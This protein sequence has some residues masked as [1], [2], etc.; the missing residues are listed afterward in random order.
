MH[1]PG[2]LARRPRARAT[3]AAAGAVVALLAVL[4]STVPGA[5]AQATTT[6]S[7]A[8]APLRVRAFG[9]SITAGYGFLGDGTEWD[10]F[11][12]LRCRPPV[13][14]LNDRC[15]S[16][17]SLGPSSPAGPPVFTPDFG[18]ANN[19]S[20][21]AQVT[22]AL[23]T[24]DY[25]NYSVTGSE[26]RQWMNLAPEPDQPD[27]GEYHD[28]LERL[29]SDDP[30][31]VLATL[32]AN[33]LLATFLTGPGM[34]CSEFADEATQRQYFVDC[35][36][37]VIDDNLVSQRLIAVY[38]DILAHTAKAKVLVTKY[39]LAMPA[40]SV[41]DEW[42]SQVMVDA[43]NAQIDTA[44]AS[45]KESGAAFAERI[46]V[47]E[48]P[49]FDS[50]WPGTGQDATCGAKVP[51]DGPSH[52]SLFAQVKMLHQAGAQGFCASLQPWTIDGDTGIHPNRVGHAQLAASAL[53]VIRANGWET[54]S[55]G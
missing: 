32:G 48:P 50:G 42:Q 45:V 51:A 10:I 25:A 35:I 46:A 8:S 14:E 1:A 34:A 54:P 36:D 38:L 41:F 52:Q 44:V 9:D 49:R 24:K 4:A 43:V 23:G 21:A 39:Y 2:A 7:V 22:N 40:M 55:G 30:D 17:S 15:S 47:S 29:E 37:G 31:L 33:P 11:S 12:L 20:W 18:L 16:N 26:P 53:A 3:A 6:T 27:N 5:G 19:V 13:G 28:L